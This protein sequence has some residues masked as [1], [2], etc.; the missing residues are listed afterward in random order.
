MKETFPALLADEV[1]KML[2]AKNSGMGNKKPKIN[3]MTRGP[4]RREVMISMTKVNT[5]LIINSANIHISNVNNCLKNSKSDIIADFIQINR[6]GIIITTN[7]PANNLNLSIIK[8][9][10]KNVKNVN[11][12]SI[13]SSR[14]P[15]VQVIHENCWTSILKQ[16]MSHYS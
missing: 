12:D 16:I 11:P 2:K 4:S 14:L 10:L 6:N 7:K 5:E 13:E 3:M 15:Q 1:E 8:K 9:Y